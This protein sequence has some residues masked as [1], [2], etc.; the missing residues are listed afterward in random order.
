MRSIDELIELDDPRWPD[1]QSWI[2]DATND[3]NVF[4]SAKSTRADALLATQVTTRSPMGAIIYE[5][6]GITV[7]R[8][9][10]RILGSGCAD[11]K[12][13]LPQWNRDCGTM[14]DD[15]TPHFLLVADDVV[16]GFFAINGGSLG[17]DVGNVYYFAPDT[18]DWEPFEMS[19]TDF[20]LW[21]FSGDLQSFYADLR[22]TDWVSEIADLSPDRSMSFQPFLW[23]KAD[24]LDSRHRGSVPVLEAFNLQFDLARQLNVRPT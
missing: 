24:S 9:W 18:L 20:I 6:G 17:D 10:L 11:F 15:S 21:A 22:W 13:S 1:L 2:A 14:T 12:R 19:Y 16:G 7:D 4:P 23:A 8:G 5:S 3:V